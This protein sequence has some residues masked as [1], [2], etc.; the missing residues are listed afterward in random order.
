MIQWPQDIM[1][2]QEIIWRTKPDVIVETGI[3][4]GG[5]LIFTSSMLE[6]LGGDG[7]VIGVDIDIRAHNRVAIEQHPMS[8]RI[9]MIEGSSIDEGI[10]GQVAHLVADA[11]N[12]MVILDSNHTHEHVLAELELYA[13]MVRQGG[14]IAVMDTVV[15]DMPGD[16]FPDRPWDRDD[17]PGTALKAFLETEAEALRGRHRALGPPRPQR[18]A[19]RLP[20]GHRL[21]VLVTG[22][23]GYVGRRVTGPLEALGF[24]VHAAGRAQGVDLLATGGAD[25]LLAQVQPTHLLHLAWYTE[26]G[27]FWT[28]RENLR[29]VDAS[30]RLLQAFASGGGRRA[31]VAGTCAEYDWVPGGTFSEWRTPLRPATLYGAAK[32][33]LHEVWSRGLAAQEGVELAWGAC[34]PRSAPANPRDGSCPRSPG[35]SWRGRRLR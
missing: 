31:V 28:S 25:A 17:N 33:G 13:P 14:Y 21:R 7:R 15:E 4:H 10:V 18:R 34:S 12:V 1:A 22:A 23:T 27:L 35:R 26:H 3:A 30:L 16:A 6:L 5:S 9:T 11:A 19:R 20:E 24:E 29:W 8:K 2:L 32:L